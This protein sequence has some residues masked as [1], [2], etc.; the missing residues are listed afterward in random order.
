MFTEIEFNHK[1]RT[2]KTI[3]PTKRG[4]YLGKEQNIKKKNRENE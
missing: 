2:I 4:V 3:R 1:K